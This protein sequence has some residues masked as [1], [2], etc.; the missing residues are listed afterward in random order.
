MSD[1]TAI[2]LD[3]LVRAATAHGIHEKEDLG[4]VYDEDWPQWYAEHI[5]ASLRADGLRI[6]SE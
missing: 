4:G 1:T 3:L 5:V 6:V 2:V